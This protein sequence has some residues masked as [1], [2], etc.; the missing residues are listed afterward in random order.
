[1]NRSAKTQLLILAAMIV[2]AAAGLVY[3]D[4][5]GDPVERPQAGG[6]E[7]EVHVLVY[8]GSDTLVHAPVQAAPPLSALSALEH[9]A[10]KA[11]LPVGIRQYDFGKLV[12][13]IG[14]YTAGVEGDWTYRVNDSLVPVAAENCQLAHG[15]RLEFRFSQSAKG[16]GESPDT[17]I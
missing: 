15:D 5:Q 2:V 13:S 10:Q 14:G 3:F 9:A 8:S 6:P 4:R 12:V 11:T 16:S 1:M 7:L 17:S